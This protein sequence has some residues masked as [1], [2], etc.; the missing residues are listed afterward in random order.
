MR[1]SMNGEP[2]LFQTPAA[3]KLPEEN[4]GRD[5]FLSCRPRHAR[6][7]WPYRHFPPSCRPPWTFGWTTLRC[8]ERRIKAARNRTPSRGG[9]DGYMGF[10]TL[11]EGRHPLPTC[12]LQKTPQ[13][14]YHAVVFLHPRLDEEKRRDRVA[15]RA[16]NPAPRES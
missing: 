8:E 5:L 9:C 13:T 12:G 6:Y 15:G 3:L 10:R 1:R 16:R 4:R 2:F 11:A 7:A 14:A